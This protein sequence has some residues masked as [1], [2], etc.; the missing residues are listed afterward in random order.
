MKNIIQICLVA[1]V[2]ALFTGCETQNEQ[3]EHTQDRQ[4]QKLMKE[5]QNEQDQAHRVELIKQ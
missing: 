1:T 4:M 5:M 2:L 3:V